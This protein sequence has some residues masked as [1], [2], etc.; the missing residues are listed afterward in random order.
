MLRLVEQPSL[1]SGNLAIAAT[2]TRLSKAS[3]RPQILGCANRTVFARNLCFRSHASEQN[4]DLVF[5]SVF[6]RPKTS[7]LDLTLT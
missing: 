2:G 5:E 3:D 7:L 1:Q 6:A 4:Q